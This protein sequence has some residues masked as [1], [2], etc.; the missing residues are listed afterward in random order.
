MTNQWDSASGEGGSPSR[1]QFGQGPREQTPSFGQQWQP[2]PSD[3][4]NPERQYPQVGNDPQQGHYAQN[5]R[6]SQYPGTQ[7][8][9][10]EQG[11]RWNHQGQ[12]LY[13]APRAPYT[14]APEKRSSV[15]GAVGLVLVVVATVLLTILSWMLAQGFANTVLDAFR[16]LEGFEDPEALEQNLDQLLREPRFLAY[17]QT[18]SSLIVGIIISCLVGLAG[19]ITSIVATAQNRGRVLGVVGIVLGVLAVPVAYFF[20]VAALSAGGIG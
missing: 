11:P 1:P 2:G 8:G 20:G 10:Y 4:S 15:L 13:G 19:W 16:N 5:P 12:P 3:Q 7:S 6:P 9:Q 14:R 18:A 17:M